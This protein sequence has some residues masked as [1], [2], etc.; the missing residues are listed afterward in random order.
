MI[1]LKY[2]IQTLLAVFVISMVGC[3]TDEAQ[4]VII[5]K[6]LEQYKSEFTA[7]VNSE[8]TK[9]ETCVVGFDKGN[10]RTSSKFDA[11]KAD[12]LTVLNAAELVLAKTDVT[13]PDI[14][15]SQK[16]L[17]T[18]GKAFAAEY[19]LT[20]RRALNDSIVACETLNTATVA[21]TA[22]SQVPT[23]DKTTF[24]TAI[25]TAKTTRSL[26]SAIDR[27]VKEATDKLYAA[28]TAFKAAII[29]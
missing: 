4:T 10:F 7:F 23:A 12:Y 13:I 20:D 11:I 14:I 3:T 26:V 16:T 2:K 24:T 18:A 19:Y 21:G 1:P 27:Q 6:T 8:K 29:K 17:S 9:V 28:K 22:V 25:T 15:N 5:P